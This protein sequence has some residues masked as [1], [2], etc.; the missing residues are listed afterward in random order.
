MLRV[1]VAQLSMSRMSSRLHR[2]LRNEAT[3]GAASSVMLTGAAAI[4]SFGML[5]ALAR[6][7]STADFGLLAGWMNALLF[8]SVVA[9]FGQETI[10]VRHWNEFVQQRQFGRARGL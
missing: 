9:V 6:S 4:T 1:I 7:M 10:F 8:L 3:V 2:I 5:T